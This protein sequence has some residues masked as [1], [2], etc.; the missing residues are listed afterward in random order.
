MDIRVIKESVPKAVAVEIA[1]EFYVDMIKGA[2]D[3]ER[4]IIALGGEWHSDANEVLLQDG[5]AQSSVWG[6][7]FYLNK[8]GREQ[9]ECHSLINIRPTE[10]NYS[11]LVENPEIEEKIRS[12]AQRLIL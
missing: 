9:I 10:G 1:K 7:N 3:V 6:F 4:G 2:V 5:S 12:L 11:M 8:S